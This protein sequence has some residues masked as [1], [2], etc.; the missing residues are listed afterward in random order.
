[1]KED[2]EKKVAEDERVEL[3]R[4]AE[5]QRLHREHG[6]IVEEQDLEDAMAQID[7]R[8]QEREDVNVFRIKE[9]RARRNSLVARAADKQRIKELEEQ[10]KEEED[11]EEQV[12]CV[13]VCV[14]V[15]VFARVRVVPVK[16]WGGEAFC[17]PLYP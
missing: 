12:L 17:L 16:C 15:C 3:L 2:Y 6:E 1:M 7:L 10:E 4:R 9:R 5:M 11:E 8:H 13:C 14:C